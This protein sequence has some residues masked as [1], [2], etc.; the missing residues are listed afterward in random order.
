MRNILSKRIVDSPAAGVISDIHPS[1][2]GA[3]EPYVFN[4][5][6]TMMR[7]GQAVLGE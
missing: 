3:V 4:P 2:K 1:K 5:T 7:A 6:P